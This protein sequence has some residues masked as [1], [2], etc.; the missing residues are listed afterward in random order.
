MFGSNVLHIHSDPSVLAG[1]LLGHSDAVWGL[2]YS[3]IKNRLLSC[4]ADGTIKLWNPQEKSQ[5]LSTLNSD[6][7]EPN[8][9]FMCHSANS[10]SVGYS[11]SSFPVFQIMVFPHRSTLM[12]VIQLIW[13]RPITREMLSCTIWR[14]HSPSWYS[15]RRERVVHSTHLFFKKHKYT[16][17]RYDI[18]CIYNTIYL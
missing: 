4:S 3:G 17:C 12:G 8:A 16:L 1:T 9:S 6:R 2:A 11:L 18:M 5:C 13:W 7:G 10:W 14:H 15:L